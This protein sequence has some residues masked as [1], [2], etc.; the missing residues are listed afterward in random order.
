MKKINN[1]KITIAI[2]TFN[3]P[4]LVCE[5]IESA[6]KQKTDKE[7]EIIV[8]DN[9]SDAEY[10]NQYNDVI[11]KYKPN[12]VKFFKNNLNIGMYGNWNK[13][14]QNSSGKYLTILNDDDLLNEDFISEVSMFTEDKTEL[15]ICK[16]QVLQNNKTIKIKTETKRKINLLRFRK[17]FKGNPANGSAGVLINTEVARELNGFDINYNMSADYE[18]YARYYLKYGVLEYNKILA[19]YRL[20]GNN[21]TFKKGVIESYVVDSYKIRENICNEMLPENW[22]K[23]SK[24]VNNFH[25]LVQCKIY[26]NTYVLNNK[27][28]LN[29]MPKQ[30]IYIF[31]KMFP[32]L[33]LRIILY[34]LVSTLELRISL[35]KNK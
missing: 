4:D 14:I 29:L 15:I 5:A 24:I 1:V 27:N 18:F 2:P 12:G 8:I 21:E 19:K 25:K 23:F 6:I 20:H 31:F 30:K 32:I 11:E 3:R 28:F 33:T 13:C 10:Q 9:C 35:I 22:R 17:I 34:I 16:S 7:Y 26:S